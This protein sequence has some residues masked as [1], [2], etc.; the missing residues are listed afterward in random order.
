MIARFDLYDFV[1]NL[2]P[3]LVFLWCVQVLAG[4]FGWT[5][6]L[7]FA[8]GLAETSILVALGYVTGLL[9]QGLSQWVVERRIL[10]PLWGGFPSE[11]WLLPDDDHFSAAYRNRLLALIR[12]RLG[13]STDPDLPPDC[14]RV[15]ARELRLKMNRELFFLIYRA[16]GETSPRPLIFNAQYGLFRALLAVFSLLALLSLAGL[17]W[18][19]F[20]RCDHAY[21]FASWTALFAVAALISYARCKKRGEDFAQSVYDLFMVGAGDKTSL[22]TPKQTPPGER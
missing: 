6:P 10:K 9:L 15:R 14:P 19:F 17:L 12:E 7:D 11:R 16:V 21:P 8:G 18:A 2:I 3:G 1:A 20:C 4:L 5:L 13:V 22:A